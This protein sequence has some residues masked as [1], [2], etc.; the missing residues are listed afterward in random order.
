[1]FSDFFSY[2][3]KNF[4]Y[5]TTASSNTDLLGSGK[6]GACGSFALTFANLVNVALGSK[7]ATASELS[8]KNFYTK[9]L[10]AMG[11]IDPKC[12][13]NLVLEGAIAPTCYFFSSHWITE[14]KS[15][16]QYDPTTGRK[17]GAISGAVSASG[18]KN[19]KDG[20][21]KGDLV[22]RVEPRKGYGGGGLYRMERKTA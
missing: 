2:G 12:P 1:M 15:V 10:K 20:Y 16:G 22:I 3:K 17:G 11:F 8:T 14:V 21:E 6:T 18:F 7:V 19:T 13:G 5:N 9:P 4:T